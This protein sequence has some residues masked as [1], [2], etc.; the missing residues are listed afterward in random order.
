MRRRFNCGGYY[1]RLKKGELIG[2][3]DKRKGN[4]SPKSGQLPKT[5]SF[6]VRYYDRANQHIATVHQFVRPDGT[7]GASGLPDP[8]ALTENGVLY[9]CYKSDVKLSLLRKVLA[10]LNAIVGRICRWL[11][12]F[13]F[14]DPIG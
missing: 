1:K 11:E 10:S 8:K 5:K 12:P 14:N 7:I 13:R 2:R 6:T 9:H 4:A 3:E